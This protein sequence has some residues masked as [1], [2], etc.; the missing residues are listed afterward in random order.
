MLMTSNMTPP[1][2]PHHASGALIGHTGFVGQN[3]L[4]QTPFNALYNSKNASS[5]RGQSFELVVCAAAPAEKWRAN[6]FPDEDLKNIQELIG[7]L[8]T[9]R[10]GRLVLISTIDVYP[11][12]RGV[13]EDSPAAGKHHA[14]GR[15]RR[16]LEDFV[17]DHFAAVILR[18]P[19]LFGTGLKKN[20]LY[21]L[22]QGRHPHAI[23]PDGVFQFY[24]LAH[25]WR[26]IVV[27]L[28]NQLK[29]VNIC[30][31]PQ[32]TQEILREVFNLSCDNH[33]STPAPFYD[34]RTRHAHCW[35]K[36]GNYQYTK[37]EIMGELKLF[38]SHYQSGSTK[39]KVEM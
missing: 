17:Q 34:M 9:L 21:D 39:E 2:P 13:Y 15:H 8:K 4:S 35:G 28:E 10:A 31:E 14:Y 23:H 22:L 11:T 24:S 33:L 20:M 5:M 30:S 32:S 6:Q 37:A 26:D 12:V 18:L 3:I 36:S 16:L 7:N 29:V 1:D 25:L 27:T 38:V 19:A